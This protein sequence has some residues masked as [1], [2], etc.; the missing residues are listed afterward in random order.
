MARR[1]AL[2]DREL[3]TRAPGPRRRCGSRAWGA[4]SWSCRPSSTGCPAAS[5]RAPHRPRRGPGR[6]EGR[7][8]IAG[9]R[10]P[11]RRGGAR[12]AA[13]AGQSRPSRGGRAGRAL[14]RRRVFMHA[15]GE[16]VEFVH[17]RAVAERLCQCGLPAALRSTGRRGGRSTASSSRRWPTPRSPSALTPGP[18]GPV[19]CASC[20]ARHASPPTRVKTPSGAS[21]GRIVRCLPA[22]LHRRFH[23]RPWASS[24]RPQLGLRHRG[25]RRCH[26]RARRHRSF[27]VGADAVQTATAA[28][29]DPDLARRAAAAANA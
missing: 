25:H 2:R 13:A 17:R 24:A 29:H 8:R 27:A 6:R 5:L 21:D 14:G 20:R 28:S 7:E 15:H 11:S 10:A 16:P 26:D 1:E 23:R 4:G 9:D 12:P 3:R 19:R 22:T 18:V